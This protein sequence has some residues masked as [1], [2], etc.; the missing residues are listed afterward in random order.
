LII[1][2]LYKIANIQEGTM[3]TEKL[4]KIHNKLIEIS[5]LLYVLKISLDNTKQ[6]LNDTT[7]FADLAKIIEHKI[8]YVLEAVTNQINGI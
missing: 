8:N 5:S 3:R 6:P 4:S 7:P 2:A 1:F